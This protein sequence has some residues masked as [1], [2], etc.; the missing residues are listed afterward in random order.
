MRQHVTLNKQ[1]MDMSTVSA[2]EI[3]EHRDAM[4]EFRSI[5]EGTLGCVGPVSQAIEKDHLQ[6]WKCEDKDK[7]KMHRGLE[8]QPCGGHCIW[9]QRGTVLVHTQ[10]HA[11]SPSRE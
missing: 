7:G 2:D 3:E 5:C 8:N 6:S 9:Q 1:R 11:K 10:V 4:E